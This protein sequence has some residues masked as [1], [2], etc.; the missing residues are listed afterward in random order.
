MTLGLVRRS[1][2][3]DF[4]RDLTVATHPT[5]LGLVHRSEIVDFFRDLRV[6]THPTTHDSKKNDDSVTFGVQA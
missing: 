3:I 2:I 5:T 1:S 6:A 4:F